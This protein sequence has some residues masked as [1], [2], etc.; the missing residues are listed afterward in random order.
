MESIRIKIELSSVLIGVLGG[1]VLLA[2][3]FGILTIANS[4]SHAVEQFVAMWYWILLLAAGFGTQIGL[5]SHVRTSVHAKQ[6]AGATAEVATA[7]GISTGSMIACCAH[8]ITD[9]IPIL[10]LSAAAVFLTKYQLAFIV[11]G[12]FSNLVGITMMLNIIQKHNLFDNEGFLKK[13]FKYNMVSVRNVAIVASLIIVSLAFI[14]AGPLPTGLALGS[15]SSD[16]STAKSTMGLPAIIKDENRVSF[17][18]TPIEFNFDNPVRFDVA[19]N[20]HQGSLDFDLTEISIME[21]GAGNEYLPLSWDGSPSGGHHRY[22]VL[23]FPELDE[24]TNRIR[25]VI[26]GVY[27]V[28][29][30][31]FIWDLK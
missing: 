14:T 25:L 30:R 10:G 17:E 11:L 19:I 6:M 22:G 8:H 21:D 31:I 16:S 26:K 3:Y 5:Y 4:F 24:D 18:V 1:L 29:E 2:L 27:D 12:V 13:M 23:T 15:I 9:V 20:T 7:G 28:A